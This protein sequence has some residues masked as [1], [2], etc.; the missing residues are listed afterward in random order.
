MTTTAPMNFAPD[1]GCR[2]DWLLDGGLSTSPSSRR[3]SVGRGGVFLRRNAENEHCDQHPAV[4]WF[5][6]RPHPSPLPRGEGM[7]LGSTFLFNNHHHQSSVLIARA[8]A[9]ISPSPRGD[10]SPNP[11]LRF[12]PRNRSADF[13]V[14]CIAGFQTRRPHAITTRR[15]LG[16]RRYS[17]FG[18][19]RYLVAVQGQ[20]ERCITEPKKFILQLLATNSSTPIAP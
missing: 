16:H 6:A 19:L 18:N 2:T 12:E 17:R 8:T 4:R 7:A 3:S 11:V 20:G 15:R 14:C 9:N 1:H 10:N 13:Q 5:D